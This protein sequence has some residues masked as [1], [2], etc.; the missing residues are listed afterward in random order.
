MSTTNPIYF[1]FF[2]YVAYY[3]RMGCLSPTQVAAIKAEIVIID[4]QIDAANTALLESIQSSK[5]QEYRF[6]SGDGSQRVMNRSPKEINSLI[7]ELQSSRNRLQRKL[8]GTSNVN[9]NLRRSRGYYGRR[10]R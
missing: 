2:S 6:D 4:A 9:M 8:N 1:D 7:N 10:V 3:L 5:T